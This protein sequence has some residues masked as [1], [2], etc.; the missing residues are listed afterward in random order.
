M[1]TECP[2]GLNI[3]HVISRRGGLALMAS[4]LVLS[5]CGS[6]G[7]STTRDSTTFRTPTQVAK[8]WFKAIDSDEAGAAR[9]LFEPS[10]VDQIAWMNE[11]ASDQSKFTNIHCRE[12][13][14]TDMTASVLCTFMESASSTEG[15]P[16]TFWNISFHLSSN[17]RWLISSYGQG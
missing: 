13:S 4:G 17:D 15:N 11:P 14:V 9:K 8:E 16:D 6:V 10:Q 1:H 7:V 2:R 3:P 12:T 5:G